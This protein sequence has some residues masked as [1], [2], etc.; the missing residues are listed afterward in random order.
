MQPETMAA[1]N[2][3]WR[4]QSMSLMRGLQT[5]RYFELFRTLWAQLLQ[6]AAKTLLLEVKSEHIHMIHIFLDS[7]WLT[8]FKDI[9]ISDAININIHRS[10]YE[11][12]AW[13]FVNMLMSQFCLSVSNFENS[14]NIFSIIFHCSCW[15]YLVL[16]WFSVLGQKEKNISKN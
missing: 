11:K 2:K 7:V 5:E 9:I 14:C 1:G 3:S 13:E 8:L 4:V 12:L 10:A 15:K 6:C 16:A